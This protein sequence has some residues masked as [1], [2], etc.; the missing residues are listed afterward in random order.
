MPRAVLIFAL[1]V[2]GSTLA[3]DRTLEPGAH[4]RDVVET[5]V[6]RIHRSRVFPDD[7]DFF[8]RVA[9]TESNFGDDPRTY[10]NGYYGGIWQFDRL[11]TTQHDGP[12]DVITP[13]LKSIHAAIKQR[14]GIDWMQVKKED[15]LKPF[16]SGLAAR[17]HIEQTRLSRGPIPDDIHGQD[18]YWKDWYHTHE[19]KYGD[20]ERRAYELLEEDM[21]TAGGKLDMVMVVD[22]S[23]SI[24]LSNFRS[25]LASLA[26]LVNI[27]DLQE[28]NVGMVTYSDKVTSIIPLVNELNMT[29]LQEAIRQTRYP[30]YN[31]NTY[32]GMMAAIDEFKKLPGARKELGIPQLMVVFTDGEHNVDPDPGVSAAKAAEA[33]IITCSFGIGNSIHDDELLRIANN[34]SDFKFNT[35]S[36][37]TLTEQIVLIARRA[38][39]VPQ[40]P[41]MGSETNET[42]K[43][44]GDKRYYRLG[45]PDN[46][47]TIILV[48]ERGETRGY[49]TYSNERPSSAFYDGVITAGETFIPPPPQ[50]VSSG[51]VRQRREAIQD[52]PKRDVMI[53]LESFSTDSRV[54]M[55]IAAGDVT[56]SGATRVD[57]TCFV[58]ATVLTFTVSLLK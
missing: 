25:A 21:R 40:T 28:A 2:F 51:V 33:G 6:Y 11:K 27:F 41:K 52:P 53:A 47:T 43:E 24:G 17:I 10:R 34:E 37:D 23:A 58:L 15:L 1:C 57:V 30:A 45:V 38:K 19:M 13:Q 35:N 48:N 32:A 12:Y 54:R 18:I 49:W 31:T 5:V 44:I 55:K 36:Y 14:M 4:G 42:L 7:R 46:G 22:G 29:Q 26:R 16:Y 20:Y 39:T 3:V 50:R 8:R 9:Y 56:T